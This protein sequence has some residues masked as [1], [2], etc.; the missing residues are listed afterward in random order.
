[1]IEDQVDQL[2][3]V[4]KKSK[5]FQNYLQQ[6]RTMYEDGQVQKLRKDFITKREAFEAIAAYGKYAPDRRKKQL[7]VREA[8]RAL[9][10]H[11]K[12]AE[13][14]YA[15]TKLQ[16]VLDV[17]GSTIALAISEEIKVDAGNPFFESKTSRGGHCHVR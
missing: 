16:T 12:V 8:K 9:D 10:L 4:L 2:C 1:M 11:P 3:D 7:A 14:H 17:I 13:F 5:T 15:E 6:K